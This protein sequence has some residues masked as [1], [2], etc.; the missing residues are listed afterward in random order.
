MKTIQP[1]EGDIEIDQRGIVAHI[2]VIQMWLI[3]QGSPQKLLR[4]A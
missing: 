1:L 3:Q 2:W 4:S